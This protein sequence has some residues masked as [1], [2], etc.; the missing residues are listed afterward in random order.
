MEHH[1][2]QFKSCN[3]KI[4][5]SENVEVNHLNQ[6]ILNK[7][8]SNPVKV[9]WPITENTIMN[10]IIVIPFLFLRSDIFEP[11]HHKSSAA[12]KKFNILL[13]FKR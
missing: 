9:L 10:C 1:S 2:V 7:D 8:N 11:E 5:W 3:L 6:N 12:L 4:N 13:K